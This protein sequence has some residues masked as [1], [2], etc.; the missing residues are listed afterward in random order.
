MP[1]RYSGVVTP[2]PAKT[3]PPTGDR[4]AAIMK[5]TLELAEEVGY[6]RLSIES[7]ASRAGVGK[8]TVYRRWPSKGAIFLDALLSTVEPNIGYAETGDIIADLREQMIAAIRL[9]ASPPY[10]RLYAALV[11]E[12]QHDP[13]VAQTLY[14]RFIAPQA[15]R[16]VDRLE[17]ARQT[18]QL[19]ADLDLDAAVAVLYGPL[20]FV[21]LLTPEKLS[22]TYVDLLL[23]TVFEVGFRGPALP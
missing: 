20:Y 11:G 19:P 1:C 8:H 21:F 2:P 18:G 9:L 14:D 5:A 17:K 23:R 6:A 15:A 3:D 7:I 16:T 4:T 12:A 10:D 22:E 13:A